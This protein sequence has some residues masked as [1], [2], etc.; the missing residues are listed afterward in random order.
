MYTNLL[1]TTTQYDHDSPEITYNIIVKFLQI[2]IWNPNLV[3]YVL[4]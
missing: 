1:I 4:I 3:I 2:F